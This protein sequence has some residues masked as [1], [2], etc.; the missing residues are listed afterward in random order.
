MAIELNTPAFVCIAYYINKPNTGYRSVTVVGA[1]APATT[2]TGHR[3]DRRDNA[4]FVNGNLGQN[5]F[6]GLRE[7][8]THSP[9]L[10]SRGFNAA[11]VQDGP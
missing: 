3:I 10:Y 11:L 6:A 7:K 8:K 1:T 2:A 5:S 4:Q 9:S